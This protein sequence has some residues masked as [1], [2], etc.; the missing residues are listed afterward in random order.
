MLQV[1]YLFPLISEAVLRVFEKII[2]FGLKWM[3]HS[4][5]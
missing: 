4:R 3:V 1:H 5:N 2:H